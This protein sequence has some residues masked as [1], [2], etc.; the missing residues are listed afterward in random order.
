[1]DAEDIFIMLE[2]YGKRAETIAQV[3]PGTEIFTGEY[4]VYLELTNETAAKQLN[5]FS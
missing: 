4:I 5:N 3:N 2:Q 1:M